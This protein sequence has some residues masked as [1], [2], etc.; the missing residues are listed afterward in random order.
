M[1]TFEIV[2]DGNGRRLFTM[3]GTGSFLEMAR[4]SK[5]I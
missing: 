2:S 1:G 3:E 4:L 5:N